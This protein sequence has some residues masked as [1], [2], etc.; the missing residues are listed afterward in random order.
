M[1]LGDMPNLE[2]RCCVTY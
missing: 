1:N 2:Q